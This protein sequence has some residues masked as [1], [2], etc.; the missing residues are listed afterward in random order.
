MKRILLTIAVGLTLWV[1][2]THSQAPAPKSVVE[3]LK[4]IRDQNIKILEDQ[5]KTIIKLEE[6]EKTTQTLKV[7]GKRS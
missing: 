7:L 2:F 1:P 4:A 6:M 5:A 3:Q